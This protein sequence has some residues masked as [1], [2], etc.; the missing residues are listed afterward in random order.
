MTVILRIAVVPKRKLCYNR[1]E[2]GKETKVGLN[3][4]SG[5]PNGFRETHAMHKE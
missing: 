2:I 3:V 4:W 1:V 5:L